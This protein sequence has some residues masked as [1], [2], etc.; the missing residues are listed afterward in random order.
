[1]GK[2]YFVAFLY[3]LLSI[4]VFVILL[5]EQDSFVC[6]GGILHGVDVIL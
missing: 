1:M 3:L 4:D 2:R 5:Y 6:I